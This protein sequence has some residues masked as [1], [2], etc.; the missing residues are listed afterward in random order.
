MGVQSSAASGDRRALLEALRDNISSQIDAGVPPRD[1]ASL[2]LR[3]LAIAGEIAEIDAV[4]EGD[5]VGTAAETPDE[6]WPDS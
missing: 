1:L 4:E 2:S 3:L 5:D 6:P